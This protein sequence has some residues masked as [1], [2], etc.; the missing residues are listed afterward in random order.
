MRPRQSL[1]AALQLGLALLLL[2]G[3]AR[4]RDVPMQKAI[5]PL[6]DP[7]PYVLLPSSLVDFFAGSGLARVSIAGYDEM[8]EDGSLRVR[9]GSL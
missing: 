7:I 6:M 9:L 8:E 4:G 3:A 5:P 2:A 1:A